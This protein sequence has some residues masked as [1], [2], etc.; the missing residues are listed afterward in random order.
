MISPC[1]GFFRR[2]I[3]YGIHLYVKIINFNEIVKTEAKNRNDYTRFLH[4]MHTY[5]MAIIKLVDSFNNDKIYIEKLTAGKLHLV[6]EKHDMYIDDLL[7]LAYSVYH[8][9]YNI[10][11]GLNKYK[12]ANNFKIAIGADV[13][14]YY[15]IDF[16][17]VNGGVETTSVGNCANKASKI[18]DKTFAGNFS[19][20]RKIYNKLEDINKTTFK[21]FS[22]KDIRN[23][24]RKYEDSD[25]YWT[26]LNRLV[27]K[28]NIDFTEIREYVE[29][30][31]QKQNFNDVHFEDARKKIDFS[32]L[33]IRKNKIFAGT[34]LYADINGFTRMF[35]E[36]DANLTEM[37]RLTKTILKNMND[38]VKKYDGVRVQFQGDR[39]S[40]I[41]HNHSQYKG[42]LLI[43]TCLAALEFISGMVDYK[44]KY[45][46]NEKMIMSDITMSVG[47][48]YGEVTAT[49]SGSKKNNNQDNLI[50]GDVVFQAD[51][52]EDFIAN[53]DQV[54]SYKN[55][56]EKLTEDN[57]REAMKRLFIVSS[58]NRNYFITNKSKSDYIN[59]KHLLENA[60]QH[61]REK[62]LKPYNEL[63]DI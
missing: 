62:A 23:I 45:I 9:T 17:D 58:I 33:N 5:H 53:N 38:I 44:A 59:Y 25:F 12:T 28:T 11:N 49:R 20:S 27:K 14:K 2:K 18:T 57:E 13:G 32:L 29:I 3:M 19:I 34:V 46:L 37:T 54:S 24:K 50:I 30:G 7:E 39:I 47:I 1:E 41:F 36:N 63:F 61:R 10:F 51:Y 48:S 40:A 4:M 21:K 22:E 43:N 16:Q 15:N 52:A 60:N 56:I 6:M 42:D 35:M 26:N 31:Y 55:I 8:I